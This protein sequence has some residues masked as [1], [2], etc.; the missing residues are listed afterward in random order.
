MYMA[1]NKPVSQSQSPGPAQKP[2]APPTPTGSKLTDARKAQL[3]QHYTDTPPERQPSV[4]AH[5]RQFAD[6]EEADF[7]EKFAGNRGTMD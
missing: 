5:F 3:I 6:K 1:E 4:L 7:L 2:A